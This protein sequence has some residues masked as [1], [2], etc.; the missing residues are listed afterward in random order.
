MLNINMIPNGTTLTI[1]LEGSLDVASSPLLEAELH[2]TLDG[3]T[4]LELDLA[5]LEYITSSG[6]RV[7]LY[8]RKVMIRQGKMK[9]THVND[10]ISRIFEV[11]G[12]KNILT[13]EKS[14]S[15]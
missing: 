14:P 12:F 2:R 8:A 3:V 5:G 13:I 1:A 4:S 15:D 9:V 10:V 6:L 7:L 11:S